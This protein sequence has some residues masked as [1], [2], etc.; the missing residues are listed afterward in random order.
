MTKMNENNN[1]NPYPGNLKHHK[2][3]KPEMSD[4]RVKE[5]LENIGASKPENM[6]GH[7]LSSVDDGVFCFINEQHPYIATASR[8]D[9]SVNH[10]DDDNKR[11]PL[12]HAVLERREC[13][14]GQSEIFV[15]FHELVSVGSEEHVERVRTELAKFVHDTFK[16]KWRYK[17]GD[18][19]FTIA[20]MRGTL[21]NSKYVFLPSIP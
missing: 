1:L 13:G 19:F 14:D 10:N 8:V 11:Y 2:V 6:T 12:V 17:I 7:S 9:L 20:D 15:N 3:D 21:M 4:K 5:I 16:N 18:E